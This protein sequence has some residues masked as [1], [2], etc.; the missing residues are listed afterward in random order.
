MACNYIW[1]S[2]PQLNLDYIR[3]VQRNWSSL[4]ENYLPLPAQAGNFHRSH[5]IMQVF[6]LFVCFESSLLSQKR[7]DFFWLCVYLFQCF[8]PPFCN[9]I[10]LNA[11]PIDA[12]FFSLSSNWLCT[13]GNRQ[14]LIGLHVQFFPKC[15]GALSDMIVQ[16]CHKFSPNFCADL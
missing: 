11:F 15:D 1:L 13:P 14:Q 9:H 8:S 3:D 12:A 4:K 6:C 16:Y 10:F 5:A 7:D 2:K